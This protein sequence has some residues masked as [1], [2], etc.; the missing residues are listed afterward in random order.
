M[1][2]SGT[3]ATAQIDC[4]GLREYGDDIMRLVEKQSG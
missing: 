4:Y 1:F 3:D 2:E